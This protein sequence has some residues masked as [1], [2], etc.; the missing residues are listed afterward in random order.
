MISR[1]KTVEKLKKVVNSHT[2]PFNKIALRA[3]FESLPLFS[4]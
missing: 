1:L 2:L 3:I 4:K